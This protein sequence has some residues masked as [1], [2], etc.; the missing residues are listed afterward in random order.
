MVRN[1]T[2]ASRVAGTVASAAK[3][4]ESLKISTHNSSPSDIE[5]QLVHRTTLGRH[6]LTLDGAVDRC[7]S[8]LLFQHREL[9]R[10][11]GVAVATDESP[12]SAPR[13]RGLRFQITLIYWGT[14]LPFDAWE[15]S[16]EPPILVSSCLGD[17]TH[18]PGKKGVDVSRVIEKQLSRV[19]LNCFDVCSGTGDGGGENEGHL[20]VHA[21]F[22][23]LNPGYVRRR[24]LP[25]IAWRTCD[26]A[27]R[28]SSLDY[29]ALAAYLCEGV[30]WSRLREIA[31][32]GPAEGGLML[33][34]DASQQCKDVFGRSPSAICDSRPDT[35]LTFLKLLADKEHILHQLAVKDLEQRSLSTTT[36]DAILSLGDVK[37]RIRRRI[38]QEI[39][40]RCM[41]LL[42][43]NQ[44]HPHVASSTSWDELL[45]R[46]VCE[47]LSLDITPEVLTRF[48][49]SERALRAMQERPKTWVTLV[50][51]QVVGDEDL[52]GERM[53]DALDFHRRVSDQAAAH[54]NLLFDNTYRT[55]WLAAKLLSKDPVVAKSAAAT[56]L[57]HLVTTK[58]GNRTLF[59]DHL[60]NSMEL[61]RN[62][63][64][65]SK[66]DPPLLL[67]KGRG[68]F[69]R[70]FKF[71]APRFLLAPDHVLDAERIHARW[72]WICAAKRSLHIQS[73]NALLR[74]MF[75]LEHNQTFPSDEDLLPHL[76]AERAEHRLA[77]GAVGPGV[78]HGWRSEFLYRDRFNL[79]GADRALV[80]DGAAA[81][82]APA[83]P[84]GPFGV[85]WRNYLKNVLQKGFMYR[86]SLKPSVVLYVAENKT[87]AGK[88]DRAYEGEALGR[89]LALVFF[90]DCD[91]GLV[92]RVDRGT[93]GM[94]QQLLTLAEILQ[95]IGGVHLPPN[96]ERTVAET[97]LLLESHYQNLE[98]I[99]FRCTHEPAAPQVH[100]YTL[101]DEAHA[102]TAYCMSLNADQRTKMVLAR[103]LQRNEAL[104]E[105]ETLQNAWGESLATLR[106]RTAHLFPPPAA[107]AVP[108]P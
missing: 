96:A 33:F 92:R 19:G 20:G 89:K 58:P 73:L 108:A 59:E 54:L 55:P 44:K 102:E 106:G 64:A 86:V 42:Y 27:I 2:P 67:W 88:E 6:L 84:G 10:L 25:H 52:V 97:E 39:L 15:T 3:L 4:L 30:T 12:P 28:A 72:Q 75:Y 40:E 11:A 37:H 56:L 101:H 105:G 18:C 16:V 46:A 36:R 38:L 91:G 32:K 78:A 82:G 70:L 41:F 26:S 51:F 23:N 22:E 45:Q 100:M 31:T 48:A 95:T 63:E 66:E 87:L 21:Y 69:E 24:C 1:R 99:R 62:L 93:L 79:S 77:L 7:V 107:P 76:E 49:S 47:I 68:R 81:H 103:A 74:M 57:R 80:A 29:K 90:E 61:W 98:L 35:D 34:P 17:I 60:V 13:F 104:P 65:F 8:D 9:D 14:F 94:Q 83:V 53:E 5:D 50:V 43:Y 71:L 85:A